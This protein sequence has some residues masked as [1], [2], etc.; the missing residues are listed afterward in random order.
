MKPKKTIDRRVV[1]TRAL[2]HEALLSLLTKQSY[3]AI[4]IAQICTRAGVGRSTFYAHYATKDD[5]MRNGLAHLRQHLGAPKPAGSKEMKLA[6]SRELLEHIRGHAHLHR[7]MLGDRAGAIA[8][9]EIRKMLCESVRK[10]LAAAGRHRLPREF[11]VQYTVGAFMAVAN[12]W[13]EGGARLSPADIDAMFR[14]LALK[15]IS[16]G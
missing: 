4:T 2:L 8:R 11:V 16:A 3:E 6:F 14:Q 7:S 15:G 5:L 1:R 12:W 9:A 10:E 13:I